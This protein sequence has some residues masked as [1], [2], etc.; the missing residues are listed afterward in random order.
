MLVSFISRHWPRESHISLSPD[1]SDTS[2]FVSWM[3][4]Q[5]KRWLND[6][7]QSNR[8]VCVMREDTTENVGNIIIVYTLLIWFHFYLWNNH[9]LFL[10]SLSLFFGSSYFSNI[11]YSCCIGWYHWKRC[12][13]RRHHFLRPSLHRWHCKCAFHFFFASSFIPFV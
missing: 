4:E 13:C 1:H 9:S 6:S 8:N 5:W 2:I 7:M 10:L 12:R 3:N 11:R